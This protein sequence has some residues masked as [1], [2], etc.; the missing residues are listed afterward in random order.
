MNYEDVAN[1][2]DSTNKFITGKEATSKYSITVITCNN[3]K[4][5]FHLYKITVS[6]M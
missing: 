5:L 1:C 2:K 4:A 6:N 3:K